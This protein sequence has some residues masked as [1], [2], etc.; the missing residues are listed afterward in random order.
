MSDLVGKTIGQYQLIEVIDRSGTSIVY[1]GFQPSMNRYVAVKVLSPTLSE[2]PAFVQQFQRQ[3]ELVAQLEHRYILPVYDHGQQDGLLYMVTRYVDGTLGDRLS[4]FYAPRA[5]GQLVHF[6]AEAL[7]YVHNRGLVHGNLK[8]SNV[9]IDEQRQ[10]LLTDFGFA[11]MVGAPPDVHMSPEQVQGG[12]VDGRTDV[13]ALGVLLYEMLTGAPPPAGAVPSPRAQRP[14]LPVDVEKV[15]LKAMAQY[16][17][18]RFQTAGELSRALN[19][20][21]APAPQPAPPA[22]PPQAQPAPTP[23]PRRDTSWVVFLL[24]ALAVLCLLAVLAAVLIG[25]GGRTPGEAAPPATTAPG[26]EQP[27]PQPTPGP[28]SPDG[29]LIQGFFDMIKSV[30]ESLASIIE[31]I[32]GGQST[33]TP[34][35]PVEQLPEEPAEPPPEPEELPTEPSG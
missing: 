18:Q 26:V 12:A 34:E 2:D 4:W 30:F 22:P 23:E 6:M 25:G 13:Y 3:A 31:S 7:D 17:E 16:P 35:P 20:A 28:E 33:P 15:I 29:G 10:P 21:L 32:L 14:D 24:G 27:T 19:A 1:K 5:A 8:P 11:Q 9:F